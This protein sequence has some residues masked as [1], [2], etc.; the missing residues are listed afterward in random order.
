M[1]LADDELIE[2]LSLLDEDGDNEE[3]R[4]RS[5][6]S[7]WSN[8]TMLSA[9]S[10]LPNSYSATIEQSGTSDAFYWGNILIRNERGALV[11]NLTLS[12][13][14]RLV[15][16]HYVP[17]FDCVAELCEIIPSIIDRLDAISVPDHI[18]RSAK[19]QHSTDTW[20]RR[21]FDYV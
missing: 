21:F 13:F 7:A 2:L 8:D 15:H 14:G 5:H 18:A 11:A 3:P 9:F 20:F 10:D 16:V 17:G 1:K 4:D 12:K 19:D 6:N